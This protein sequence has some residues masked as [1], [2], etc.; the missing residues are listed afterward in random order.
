MITTRAMSALLSAHQWRVAS[1]TTVNNDFA[2]PLGAAVATPVALA[3]AAGSASAATAGSA[4]AT[5]LPAPHSTVV[6][7]VP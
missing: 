1:G 4:P 7:T 2:D 6:S 3:A 5:D